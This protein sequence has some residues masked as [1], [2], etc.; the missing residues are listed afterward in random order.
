[1]RSLRA[2][3]MGLRGA[4]GPSPKGFKGL[5]CGATLAPVLHYPHPTTRRAPEYGAPFS[6]ECISHTPGMNRN[7]RTFP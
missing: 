7:A 6:R 4:P 1:M 3:G 2:T 5:H